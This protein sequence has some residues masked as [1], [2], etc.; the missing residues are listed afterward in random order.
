MRSPHEFQAALADKHIQEVATTAYRRL[1]HLCQQHN[2]LTYDW[3]IQELLQEGQLSYAE[4]HAVWYL[5]SSYSL[6]EQCKEM[7]C[8]E[9]TVTNA[10]TQGNDV[11]HHEYSPSL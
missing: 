5:I 10:S 2:N 3:A 6:R 9:S 1:Q 11:C 7:N 8:Q 4:Y